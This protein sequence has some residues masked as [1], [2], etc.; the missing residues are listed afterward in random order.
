M[1]LSPLFRSRQAIRFLFEEKGYFHK[2]QPGLLQQK[3]TEEYISELLGRIIPQE[4]LQTVEKDDLTFLQDNFFL[5]LFNSSLQ[6]WG[7]P[8]EKID[9]YSRLNYCLR[10][11]VIAADNIGDGEDKQ[12][13]PIKRF[14]GKSFNSLFQFMNAVH[15]SSILMQESPL[16]SRENQE[17]ILKEI[18][19]LY[20]EIGSLEGSEE[21][22]ITT[23]LQPEEMIQKVHHF[24]GGN[25]FRLQFGAVH[26]LERGVSELEP[27]IEATEKGFH[28]LGTAFQIVD[29]I[30]D[31]ESDLK[32]R[33]NNLVQS[34]IHHEGTPAEKKKL[35]EMVESDR[36]PANAF[37][38]YFH[39]SGQRT[40]DYAIR[41][42]QEAF[43]SLQT[44][45]F[46]VDP[47]DSPFFVAAIAGEIGE[48]RIGILQ[49]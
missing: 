26:V 17:R 32:R 43:E 30:T 18:N 28:L 2:L 33:S 19:Q 4:H 24:R 16:V 39:S 38:N 1:T 49:G 5:V 23:I 29:D 45:G 35:K 44:I 40:L 46:W 47:A 6:N 22:G 25:L 12:A 48:T 42:A 21:Q 37:E 13:L 36:I 3:Q 11:E 31:F 41:Y 7:M 8:Q 34:I 15:V 10:S 27:K 14:E 9:L 20:Y